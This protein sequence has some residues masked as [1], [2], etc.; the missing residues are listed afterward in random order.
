MEEG[1]GARGGARRYSSLARVDGAVALALRDLALRRRQARSRLQERERESVRKSAPSNGERWQLYGEWRL[2]DAPRTRRCRRR[3]NLR[4]RS[5]PQPA[6]ACRSAC[7]GVQTIHVSARARGF[8][9]ARRTPF[10]NRRGRTRRRGCGLPQA[11]W[12]DKVQYQ[13]HRRPDRVRAEGKRTRDVAE[14]GE[15]EVDEEIA[16]ADPR[17]EGDGGRGEAASGG[18]GSGGMRVS[19]AGQASGRQLRGPSGGEANR[20]REHGQ[21][22]HEDEKDVGGA[23]VHPSA[24]SIG[25]QA[26]VDSEGR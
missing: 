26:G 8:G 22:G 24:G 17:Y 13:P 25:R 7:G 3:C 18:N 1:G 5:A 21:D 16:C 15:Q 2:E 4:A 9:R 14:E 20:V 11:R 23:V 19:G 10:W 6:S 12:E